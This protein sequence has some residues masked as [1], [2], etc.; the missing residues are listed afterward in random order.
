MKTHGLTIKLIS[1]KAENRPQLRKS[2]QVSAAMR[3]GGAAGRQQI[4]HSSEKLL[5]EGKTDGGSASSIPITV[6]KS[7]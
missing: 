4:P 5:H 3:G 2:S 1:N 6:R 7:L